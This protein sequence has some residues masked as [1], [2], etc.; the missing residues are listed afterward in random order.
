MVLAH[1]TF[2]KGKEAVC[3]GFDVMDFIFE[4]MHPSTITKKKLPPYAPYVAMLLKRLNVATSLGCKPHAIAKYQLRNNTLPSQTVGPRGS[5]SRPPFAA[6]DEEIQ[7]E[8]EAPRVRRKNAMPPGT[9]GFEDASVE[10]I[11]KEVKKLTWGQKFLMCMGIENHR[12]QHNAYLERKLMLDNQQVIGRHLAMIE[13]KLEGKKPKAPQV[14]KTAPIPYEEWNTGHIP[15]GKLDKALGLDDKGK[16]PKDSEDD[17]DDNDD[18]EDRNDG[19][20]SE[21]GSEEDEDDD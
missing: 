20:A 1:K 9:F 5:S 2:S 18:D 3:K 21:D 10:E 6:S 17:D 19:D 13:Q 11:K 15:W 8:E 7:E 12:E 14:K 4:E 16:G